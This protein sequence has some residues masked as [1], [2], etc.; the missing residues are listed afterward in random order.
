LEKQFRKDEKYCSIFMVMKVMTHTFG[1]AVELD[2]S[3]PETWLCSTV[4]Q[5]IGVMGKLAEGALIPMGKLSESYQILML[6]VC[7]T[8]IEFELI[9]TK[10]MQERKLK[11]H[12]L[13]MES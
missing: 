2:T 8:W 6:K 12:E 1:S 10:N 7:I 9:V 13:P 4:P 11:M 3:F 5:K